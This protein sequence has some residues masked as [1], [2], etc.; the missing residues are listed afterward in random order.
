ME[1]TKLEKPKNRI[2]RPSDEVKKISDNWIG[3]CQRNGIDTTPAWYIYNLACGWIITKEQ[4]EI[5]AKW[6][7]ELDHEKKDVKTVDIFLRSI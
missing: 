7:T 3:Y 1:D 6:V 5:V 2:I 4:A